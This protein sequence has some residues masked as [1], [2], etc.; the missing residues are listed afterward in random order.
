MVKSGA[1]QPVFRTPSMTWVRLLAGN[2][3]ST[4]VQFF[5]LMSRRQ[6]PT[7]SLVSWT[8]HHMAVPGALAATPK[9][10]APS[11]ESGNRPEKPPSATTSGAAP[12]MR[13]G[14]ES[15]GLLRVRACPAWKLHYLLAGMG[16]ALVTA[17]SFVVG[18]EPG[19]LRGGAVDEGHDDGAAQQQ[20]GEERHPSSTRTGPF[21]TYMAS[22]RRH[23]RRARELEE[24]RLKRNGNDRHTRQARQA[25]ILPRPN[26]GPT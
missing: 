22:T 11:L 25:Y 19:A 16:R 3:W 9:A 15:D 23:L 18:G 13:A 21:S 7:P 26:T 12:A 5:M 14:T 4:V 10:Y 24:K 6:T 1:N 8:S 17:Q 2:A 20:R